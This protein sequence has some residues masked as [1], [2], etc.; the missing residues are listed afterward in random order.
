MISGSRGILAFFKLNSQ[1]SSLHAELDN[2][3]AERLTIEHKVNLLK[4]D[5]LDLDLVEEQAKRVLGYAKAK[6]E[7]FIYED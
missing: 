6:E 5:S 2:Y 7:V 4:S 3:R 1:L